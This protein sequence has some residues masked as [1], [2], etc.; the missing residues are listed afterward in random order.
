MADVVRSGPYEYR[1]QG[2]EI[3]RRPAERY[4]LTPWDAAW[5]VLLREPQPA[6]VP[7]PVEEFFT[8]IQNP[9]AVN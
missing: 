5:L 6:V 9:A 8:L 4:G 7:Q 3:H 2:G 1:S